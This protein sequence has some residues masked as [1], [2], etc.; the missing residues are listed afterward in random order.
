LRVGVGRSFF[1]PATTGVT[2]SG[3]ADSSGALRR[4]SATDAFR[5]GV[6]AAL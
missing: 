1:A 2:G 3:G 4:N 6:I 5:S